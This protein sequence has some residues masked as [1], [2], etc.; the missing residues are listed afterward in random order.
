MKDRRYVALGLVLAAILAVTGVAL[1]SNPPQEVKP[2]THEGEGQPQ[3]DASTLEATR[4]DVPAK[5]TKVLKCTIK[6]MDSEEVAQRV[7]IALGEKFK[8]SVGQVTVDLKTQKLTLEYDASKTKGTHIISM[9]RRLG[10][11][12]KSL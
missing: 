11:A 2:H 8:G 5:S 9:L 6:G 7:A 4:G 10:Y 1:V 3:A 12:A